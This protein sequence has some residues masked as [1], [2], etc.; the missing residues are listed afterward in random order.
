V[1]TRK[2]RYRSFRREVTRRLAGEIADSGE[3]VMIVHG[4]GSFGHL[5]AAKHALHEGRRNEKQIPALARV[6]QDVRDLD[7][8]VIKELA[9]ALLPAVSI[10]PAACARMRAGVLNTLDVKLFRDYTELGAVPV[11]FGDVVLDDVKGFSIC[12]GDQIIRMLAKE[13][14]PE[15][16]IFCADVDGVYTADPKSDPK[17][18][19]LRQV[20]ST[21]LRKLSKDTSYVDV[22]GGMHGKLSNM[23]GIAKGGTDVMVI[24]GLEKGRLRAALEGKRPVGTRVVGV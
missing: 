10:P 2:D 11:T 19:L 23:V 20:D 6:M 12:S 5:L 21:Y 17:A 16:V 14:A 8:K 9:D 3:R 7:M 24:N 22:T 4:A 13:F 15:R 1:I 18:K